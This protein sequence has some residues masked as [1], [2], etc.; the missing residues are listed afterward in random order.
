MTKAFSHLAL[1][2]S[3]LLFP[4]GMDPHSHSK[5]LCLPLFGDKFDQYHQAVVN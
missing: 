4:I 3:C 2:Q 1:P 5:Q